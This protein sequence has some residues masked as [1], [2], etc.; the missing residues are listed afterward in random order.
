CIANPEWPQ[1]EDVVAASDGSLMAATDA[2]GAVSLGARSPSIEVAENGILE[3]VSKSAGFLMGDCMRSQ[4][5]RCTRHRQRTCPQVLGLC[6]EHATLK[7]DDLLQHRLLERLAV[8]EMR[9]RCFARLHFQ[10]GL[11][12]VREQVH[13]H[14]LA[15]I[16]ILVDGISSLGV[17]NVSRP[18][19]VSEV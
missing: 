12:R 10:G 14:A 7:I 13:A 6:D 16:G 5:R 9:R 4:R 1:E 2:G 15:G 3:I 18:N 19:H 8:L 17:E 11:S